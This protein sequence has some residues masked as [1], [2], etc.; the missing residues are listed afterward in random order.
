MR[1]TSFSNAEL[2]ALLADHTVLSNV[3]AGLRTLAALG[4][5]PRPDVVRQHAI[6]CDVRPD[7]IELVVA[8]MG[9]RLAGSEVLG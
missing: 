1:F 4:M 8:L 5:V 7:C 6:R 9:R 2:D 3:D